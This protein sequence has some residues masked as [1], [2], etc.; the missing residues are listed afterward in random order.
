MDSDLDE[1]NDSYMDGDSYDENDSDS[2]EVNDDY[3]DGDSCEENK[4]NCEDIILSN[5]NNQI[6]KIKYIKKLNGENLFT[7]VRF[8]QIKIFYYYYLFYHD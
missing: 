5:Y 4:S 2:D 8:Y 7:I 1:V 6:N 3:I